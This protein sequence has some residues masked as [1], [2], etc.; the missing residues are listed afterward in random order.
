VVKKMEEDEK[1]AKEREQF[2]IM[3]NTLKEG[4]SFMKLDRAYKKE[5]EQTEKNLMESIMIGK[6]RAMERYKEKE[7]QSQEKK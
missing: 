2:K 5:I 6:Q 3:E 7:E 4:Q 1:V